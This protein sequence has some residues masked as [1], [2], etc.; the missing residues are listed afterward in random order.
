MQ[1]IRSEEADKL[2]LELETKLREMRA[3]KRPIQMRYPKDIRQR[4]VGILEQGISL[5]EVSRILGGI[6]VQ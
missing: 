2:I 5:A 4:A 1:R 3:G 6:A